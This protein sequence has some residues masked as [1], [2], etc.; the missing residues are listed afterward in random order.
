MPPGRSGNTLKSA[1]AVPGNQCSRP[2]KRVF[3][4]P[5]VL[6]NFAAVGGVNGT[7]GYEGPFVPPGPVVSLNVSGLLLPCVSG[8]SISIIFGVTHSNFC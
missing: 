3:A 7:L 6:L 1:Q 4:D 2:L 5:L 8:V